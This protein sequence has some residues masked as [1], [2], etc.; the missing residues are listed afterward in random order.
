[1]SRAYLKLLFADATRETAREV[2]GETTKALL[3][4]I[5]GVIMALALT[6]LYV[7]YVDPDS[8]AWNDALQTAG[9]GVAVGAGLFV[10]GFIINL[11]LVSPYRLWKQQKDRADEAEG[12]IKPKL[13]AYLEEHLSADR[14]NA[15]RLL[16]S[17][18]GPNHVKSIEEIEQP[19]KQLKHHLRTIGQHHTVLE[20]W[21]AIESH[22]TQFQ[23]A[24]HTIA[25]DQETAEWRIAAKGYHHGLLSLH[26][27]MLDKWLRGQPV[28]ESFE[29]ECAW[30]ERHALEPSPIQSYEIVST[31]PHLRLR[32][33]TKGAAE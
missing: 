25:E 30:L 31:D 10:T 27:W 22:Y 3:W 11:L 14:A 28:A 7:G 13:D 29:Q 33:E 17:M 5:A 32:R 15:L 21:A 19:I 26:I 2:T 1:M 4:R 12:R 9:W 23:L 24:E 20:H 16:A 6:W 8:S 18:Q